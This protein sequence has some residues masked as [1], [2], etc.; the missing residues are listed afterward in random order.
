M[1]NLLM[2]MAFIVLGTQVAH[3]TKARLLALGQDKEGSLYMDDT[4]N[5]IK[6]AS[7]MNK[8]G[9]L[10]VLEYG[11]TGLPGNTNVEADTFP[12]AEGGAFF[13]AGNLHYG[14][15]LGNESDT[16]VLLKS[17]VAKSATAMP[18]SDNVLE[19]GVAGS[20]GI[21]WGLMLGYA[22]TEN[23]QGVAKTKNES[24]YTRVGVAKD[25][26]E[27]YANVSIM[28]ES[29]DRINDKKYDGSG[30][31]QVGGS[32]EMRGNTLFA[33]YQTVDWKQID[34]GV[35]TDGS[36]MEYKLGW[37]HVQEV[38]SKARMI[39]E[40]R[41]EKLE[42]ELKFSSGTA[43]AELMNAPLVVAFEA[44]A[45][46]WLTLRGSISQSL[47]SQAKE[48]NVSTANF[49]APG[50]TAVQSILRNKFKLKTSQADGKYTAS[51]TTNVNAGATLHF[52]NL[53]VDG[54]IGTG[55]A[56]GTATTTDAGTLSLDRLMTRVAMTY[57]F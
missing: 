11:G 47:Y 48:K 3:A 22:P 55:G 35:S 40:V 9:N 45:T 57:M 43:K 42:A 18:Q 4:R 36:F 1:K 15:Y 44:D 26:W 13:G 21:D 28:G 29:D 37:A 5:F 10:V 54:L 38:S 20:H 51:N 12:K 34:T 8:L 33:R 49:G 6:N 53:A 23:E 16:G 39:Y 41:Y 19:V 2:A 27:A 30:A 32:Y 25:N 31:Y 46:S 14:I 24:L 7:Y 17:L 56:D 52:G 50:T